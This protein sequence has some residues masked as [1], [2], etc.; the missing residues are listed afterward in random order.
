MRTRLLGTVGALTAVV[1]LGAA[2]EPAEP[3]MEI[4]LNVSRDIVLLPDESP[5]QTGSTALFRGQVAC[6]R[7]EPIDLWITLRQNQVVNGQPVTVED[8]ASENS[9]P[10]DGPELQDWASP[11]TF[12]ERFEP[13]NTGIEWT[14]CTN[15]GS[16]IDEDCIVVRRA[17]AEIRTK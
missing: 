2:C 16:T 10:C 3:P 4:T 12:D 1:G 7:S 17:F 9:I 8:G 5:F 11:Y 15:P 6:T 14:A 13:G